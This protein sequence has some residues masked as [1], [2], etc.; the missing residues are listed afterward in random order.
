[1]AQFGQEARFHVD[2]VIP[3]AA[4]GVTE[5]ANLALA[6]VSC[7]LRKGARQSVVD[8]VTGTTVPIFDPRRD[9]WN[10]HFRWRGTHILGLT[11]TARA[12][13]EALRFNRSLILAIREEEQARGRHPPGS[14][15]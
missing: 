4:R 11:P 2:H 3:V 13:I 6:C 12:T 14:H 8:P 9:Q 7:S 1:L 10:L 15:V 5:L